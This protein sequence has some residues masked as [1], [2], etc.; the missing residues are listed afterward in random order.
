[1]LNQS[2]NNVN[3]SLV[4]ASWKLVNVAKVIVNYNFG[5]ETFEGEVLDS[6]IQ[7]IQDFYR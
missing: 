1:M 4:R 6:S 3:N 5:F 2:I 7:I